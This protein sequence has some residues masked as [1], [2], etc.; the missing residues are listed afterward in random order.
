MNKTII[1]IAFLFFSSFSQAINVKSLHCGPRG[2]LWGTMASYLVIPDYFPPENFIT[3]LFADPLFGDLSICEE[4][5]EPVHLGEACMGHDQCYE[6]LGA[7][8]DA[9]D[10]TLFN[11]WRYSCSKRYSGTDATSS[12]CLSACTNVVE[13]M[14][15]ALRYD[16]GIFC[17]SCRAFAKDQE[18]ARLRNAQ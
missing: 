2:S 1:A 14:Y 3:Q 16:D 11:S 18:I 6:T 10:E 13:F 17:P 7:N 12:Y 15:D 8:K 5:F 9:C 4:H